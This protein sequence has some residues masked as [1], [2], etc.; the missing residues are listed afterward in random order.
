MAPIRTP[1]Q[2]CPRV[3]TPFREGGLSHEKLAR[4]LSTNCQTTRED[5]TQPTPRS[6]RSSRAR[7][8][9]LSETAGEGSIRWCGSRSGWCRIS[10]GP[11]HPPVHKGDRERERQEVNDLCVRAQTRGGIKKE[12]G[13]QTLFRLMLE[14][15]HSGVTTVHDDRSVRTRRRERSMGQRR[16]QLTA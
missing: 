6:P 3:R 4:P 9:E 8:G 1:P 10:A 11:V 15:K 2:R 7:K 14:Q 13:H 16:Q 5:H 12:I